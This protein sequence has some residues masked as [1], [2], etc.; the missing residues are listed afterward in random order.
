MIKKATLQD[1]ESI[2]KMQLNMA[3]ESE[4]IDLDLSTVI[5]GVSTIISK[6]DWGHYLIY[7]Q[8]EITLACLMV[9]YEWSD[10]RCKK[11]IWIHSVYVAPQYR[12]QG[13]YKRMYQYLLDIVHRE[14]EFSGLRLYVDKSNK[15]A[16]ST[17]ENLGMSRD[18]Y[19]LYEY[20]K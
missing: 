1:A 3:K 5:K 10:W 2:A 20:L 17:Y 6:P 12:R 16:I 9:L 15:N 18:H 13:I 8:D 7:Q 11:V 4:G 14:D 19:N